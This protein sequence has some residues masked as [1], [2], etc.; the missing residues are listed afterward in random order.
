VKVL[1]FGLARIMAP[2]HSSESI[3]NMPTINVPPEPPT[4]A[5]ADHGNPELAGGSEEVSDK[6]AVLRTAAGA[7]PFP[8]S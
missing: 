4:G 8:D 5:G 1:D 3:A 2:L 6:A 7:G